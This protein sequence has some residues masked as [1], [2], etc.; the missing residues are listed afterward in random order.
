MARLVIATENDPIWALSAW[1][2]AIPALQT[3]GHEIV[4]VWGFSPK[5]G[6]HEGKA[7][8]R[9]YWQQL[10]FHEFLSLACF[11]VLHRTFRLVRKRALTLRALAKRCGVRYYFAQSPN[12][13]VF[14][15]WL[16]SERVDV[17]MITVGQVLTQEVLACARVGTINKHA[18]FLPDNRG[19]W[20]FIWARLRGIPQAVTYHV[21]ERAVDAGSILVGPDPIPAAHCASMISFYTEVTRRFAHT[22]SV[23]VENLLAGRTKP[24]PAFEGAPFRL[25]ERSDLRAFRA[26]GGK[27]VRWKDILLATKLVP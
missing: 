21:V 23:A 18:G 14:T 19:L 9:W 7:I 1:D 22:M 26:G 16:R 10:C 20:P 8:S 5:L 2:A 3:H 6:K 17:L 25:P 4:A 13:P 12:D 24:Q 11:A 15:R 27:I